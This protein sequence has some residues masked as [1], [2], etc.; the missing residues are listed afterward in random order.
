MGSVPR[1]PV[2]SP[3]P[4]RD[5]LDAVWVR[6][7]TLVGG[8]PLRWAALRDFLVERLPAVD[9]DAWLA[10]RR[11]SDAAGRPITGDEPCTPATFIWFHKDLPDE[12]DLAGDIPV[13]H[14]DDRLLVVDK[15]HFLASIPRGV[16][17]RQTALVR[18][19]LEH[20]LPDLAPV[21]R[22]DR[23]TAGVLVFTVAREWRRPYQELFTRREARKTYEALA[24]AVLQTRASTTIRS[25]IVK[26][27]GNLQAVELPGEPPNAE[28]RIH[29]AEVRG[30]IGR[31]EL[32]PLTG[33]THQ[34][35]VHLNGLG[36]PI[37]NDPLYPDVTDAPEDPG[38]PLQ[39]VARRLSF[40]DP[41]DG[42]ERTFTSRAA[43]VWPQS[44][45]PGA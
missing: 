6:T 2:R 36:A 44:T 45:S 21:H 33:R 5:G 29:V 9:V 43:L 28:T 35:R 32:E 22:L 41:V 15:P 25:H 4:Q 42:T 38:R 26:R 8:V 17:V 11:F 23:L 13:L 12:Q 40:T 27:A 24:P 3:L 34:L 18:L 14:R 10:Q 37:L 31:Y 7:P 19:R 1:R 16:H 30:T 20:A 39:L